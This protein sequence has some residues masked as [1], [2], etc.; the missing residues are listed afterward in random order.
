MML[1]AA[2]PTTSFL[3]PWLE[4]DMLPICFFRTATDLSCPFCGL[5][6]AVAC[7]AQGAF[8]RAFDYHALWFVAVAVMMA[9]V[10][11]L[12]VDAAFALD[13]YGRALDKLK[14]HWYVILASLILFT[15]IRIAV[16]ENLRPSRDAVLCP[17]RTPFVATLHA[18]N[19]PRVP[20]D[21][22]GGGAVRP[23]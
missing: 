20:A 6:R 8:S 12:G 22:P 19:R 2:V 16:A 23:L 7:A 4:R 15:F 10:V 11:L 5:T 17:P 3:R 1:L 14:R 21:G 13:S 9:M 18:A